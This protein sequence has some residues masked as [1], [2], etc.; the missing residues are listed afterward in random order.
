MDQVTVVH[1][2]PAQR[3]CPAIEKLLPVDRLEALDPAAGVGA[4]G[5]ALEM[6]HFRARLID[7]LESGLTHLEGQIGVFVVGRGVVAVESAELGEQAGANQDRRTRTVVHLARVVE[8]R[9]VGLLES[10]IVPA[11]SVAKDDAPGFLQAAIGVDQLGAR[12]PALGNLGK[13]VHQCVQPA[14]P[15]RG[16]IV[17]KADELAASLRS[18]RIAGADE[19]QVLGV[20]DQPQAI[21]LGQ[22][23]CALIR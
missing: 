19:A 22:L 9:V 21:D 6:H 17:E 10:A 14:G 20:A 23:V 2:L 5:N 8:A 13:G 4:A 3:I 1:R 12:Q 15:D 7:H 11:V 16:V 18:A